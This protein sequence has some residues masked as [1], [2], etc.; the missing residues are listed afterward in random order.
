MKKILV[1]LLLVAAISGFAV[2]EE[3]GLT[4]GAELW[5]TPGKDQYGD[6]TFSLGPFAEF[7]KSIDIVDVYLK[8]QYMINFDDE[9]NQ[10]LYLE[11]QVT[12][13]LGAVGPG[14]LSLTL[15]NYNLFG[16]VIDDEVQWWG[17]YFYPPNDG[18]HVDNGS[19][20]R[21]TGVFEPSASYEV[22]NFSFGAG[23]PIGYSPSG[24]EFYGGQYVD[25][26][27]QFGFA[28]ESGI[29]FGVKAFFNLSKEWDAKDDKS[30]DNFYEFDIFLTYAKKGV[31]TASLEIDFPKDEDGKFMKNYSFIPGIEVYVQQ[32]ALYGKVQIDYTSKKEDMLYWRGEEKK[33]TWGFLV[34]GKMKI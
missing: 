31:F 13:N 1:V 18:I 27:G 15:N 28:H 9:K 23:L 25:L 6:N 12:F 22:D 10:A 8:G 3:L 14:S 32:F 19:V 17:V 11:E 21:V 33:T 20:K 30:R 16:T 34:G 7:E 26:F 24:K 2:A 5:N 4:V 29:D